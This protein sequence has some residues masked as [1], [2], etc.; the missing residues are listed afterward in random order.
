MCKTGFY[1]DHD[2]GGADKKY[3]CNFS[4]ENGLK[5]SWGLSIQFCTRNN[6]IFPSF[7]FA[8]SLAL[9]GDQH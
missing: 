8:S 9:A 3:S 2:L 6:Y 1:K 5:K 7:K 4:K